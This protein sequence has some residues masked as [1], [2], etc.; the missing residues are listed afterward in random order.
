MTNRPELRIVAPRL[1]VHPLVLLE[2]RLAVSSISLT[3][4][5]P[6]E[7]T[8]AVHVKAN[9]VALAAAQL[10]R[11]LREG[12]EQLLRRPQSTNAPTGVTSFTSRNATSP[13]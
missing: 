6:A 10:A 9:G 8:A 13:R 2:L 12:H 5:V 4:I 7:T 3:R 11:L 1:A